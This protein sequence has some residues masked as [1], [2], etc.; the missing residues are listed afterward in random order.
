M[1]LKSIFYED[2]FYFNKI[3]QNNYA[4]RINNLEE[5]NYHFSTNQ[6]IRPNAYFICDSF[7]IYGPLQFLNESFNHSYFIWHT[8]PYSTEFTKNSKK[9]DLVV[10]QLVE[11][12]VP[13]L[14]KEFNENS[15]PFR[16]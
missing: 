5:H 12:Y 10:L 8:L 15:D 6:T 14:L 1:G 9:I 16:L 7:M 3:N 13:M 2:Y 4:R 11:R